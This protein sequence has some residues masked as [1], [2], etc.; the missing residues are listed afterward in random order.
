ITGSKGKGLSDLED[1][2][3]RGVI[4]SVEARTALAL[5]LRREAKYGDAISVMQSLR[6]E[7]P[8]DFLFCLEVANL[9]KDDGDGPEAIQEYRLLLDQARRAGYFP[10]AHLELAWFGLGES[11]RGQKSY[12]EA[13]KAYEQAVE[14][15]TASGELRGRCELNAGEMYDI[16]HEREKAEQRY[17][18]V[19]Q[20][21]PGSAQAESARKYLKYPFSQ[22]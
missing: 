16:L 11:L 13:A 2:G 8:R 17:Q 15:P 20:N 7:Y 4:T 21:E 3:E 12:S 6:N 22:R 10:S 14:Q 1:A 5:F 9:T 18:A 19:L